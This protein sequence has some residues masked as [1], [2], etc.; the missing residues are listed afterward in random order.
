M[1]VF[2]AIWTNSIL[3]W[4]FLIA[5]GVFLI[6][7]STWNIKKNDEDDKGYESKSNFKYYTNLS[8]GILVVI[9]GFIML[10][11]EII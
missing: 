5:L 11:S 4:V 2:F 7:S 3:K 9:Y 8:L 1:E 10:A 6:W